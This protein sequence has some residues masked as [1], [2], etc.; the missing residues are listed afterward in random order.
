MLRVCIRTTQS[1]VPGVL[2]MSR[3]AQKWTTA[4]HL[5]YAVSSERGKAE[6]EH[7]PPNAHLVHERLGLGEVIHARVFLRRDSSSIVLAFSLNRRHLWR[8]IIHVSSRTKK[9]SSAG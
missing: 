3:G 4:V 5:Q 9:Q 8:A 6:P 1:N 2:L 7:T